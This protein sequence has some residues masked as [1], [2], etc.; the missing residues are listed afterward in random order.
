[1]RC[2]LFSL[3][4]F[5]QRISIIL[6]GR[7]QRSVRRVFKFIEPAVICGSFGRRWLRLFC[8]DIGGNTHEAKTQNDSQDVF[9]TEAPVLTLRVL[10]VG[11][12]VQGGA[13]KRLLPLGDVF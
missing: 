4:F 11:R 2:G 3:T 10:I 12:N 7:C 1:M 5:S 6:L 9:H 13:A 8:P